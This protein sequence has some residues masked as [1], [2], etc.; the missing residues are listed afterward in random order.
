[1]IK[2][3]YSI[4][5][6]CSIRFF[7]CAATK[8]TTVTSTLN[9]TMSDKR[10]TMIKPVVGKVKSPSYAL[11]DDDFV[12]GIESKLDKENAGEGEEGE[13]ESS[14]F[15]SFSGVGGHQNTYSTLCKT[16]RCFLSRNE[17]PLSRTKLGPKQVLG[18]LLDAKL[19]RDD[20]HGP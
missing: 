7:Q 17:S 8:I 4:V 13:D 18:T 6:L 19:P 14:F 10:V 5:N 12:Y 3:V 11:P 15:T 9:R 16:P 1:M 20:S 2:N